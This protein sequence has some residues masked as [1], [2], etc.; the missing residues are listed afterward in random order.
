MPLIT[1]AQSADTILSTVVFLA[2]VILL[3]R[4]A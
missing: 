3:L 4:H 1:W 2:L